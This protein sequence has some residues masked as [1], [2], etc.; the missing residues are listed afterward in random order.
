[1]RK[2]NYIFDNG[3]DNGI[4]YSELYE[5]EFEDEDE[6]QFDGDLYEDVYDEDGFPVVC[7]ICGSEVKWKE[8]HY[9]CLECGKEFERTEFFNYIGTEA[10][11]PECASCDNLYPGCQICKYGYIK[12]C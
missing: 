1:M 7:D 11:G 2:R 10:P 12:D 5:S 9:I 8:G 4:D 3:D 6:V